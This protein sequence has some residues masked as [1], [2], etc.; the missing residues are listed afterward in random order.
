MLRNRKPLLPLLVVIFILFFDVSVS[1]QCGTGKISKVIQGFGSIITADNAYGGS[2]GI[3][4]LGAPDGNG[5]Y[6]SN[7][8]QYIIIDLLDTVAVGQTYSFIWRQYQNVTGLSLLWWSESTDGITFNPRGNISTFN[9]RYFSEEVV[10]ST[11]TRYIKIYMQTGT[12]DFSVD[13]VSYYATKCFSDECGAEYTSQLISGNATY[14]SGISINNSTYANFVPDGTGALINSTSDYARFRLPYLIPAGQEYYIIWR[15]AQNGSQLRIRESTDGVSWSGY[16]YTTALSASSVFVLHVEKA[17]ISTGYIEISIA[18]G[19]DIYLDALVFNAISCNPPAP[20]LDVEGSYT[21]CGSPISIAPALNLTDLNN[22]V[23]NEAYVQIETSYV[24]GQDRLEC[25][26]NYGITATWNSTYG[27]LYLSGQATVAQYQSVLRTVTYRNLSGTPPLGT[28]QIVFSLERFNINTN[29]YYRFVSNSNI[30][31]PVARLDAERAFLYGMQGYLVTITSDAENDF[32]LYQM[33]S[34]GWIG[35]SDFY[36]AADD[37]YWMTGPE[38]GTMFWQG[39]ESGTVITYANWNPGAEPNNYNGN[40]EAFAHIYPSSSSLSGTWNDERITYNGYS[41]YVEFGGMPDDPLLD[42]YGI[43]TVEIDNQPPTLTGVFPTG[44]ADMD[45]CYSSI[46]V[47]PSIATI[48]ALYSD[49]CGGTITV[50]KSGTPTGNDCSWSVTYTYTVRDWRGNYVSSVPSI[51][52]SGGDQTAPVLTG[53]FPTGQT[54]MD[55]CYGDIPAGP[56]EAD[57]AAL[58]T[59]AC[60]GAI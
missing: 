48:A 37:W 51:T 25:T 8:G 39:E 29:H 17:G 27:V 55:L 23:V 2:T 47:G 44:Q 50:T 46:P 54:G 5:A 15:P 6:F 28:K 41:Y 52:Y 16:K 18:N 1:A 11:P 40:D 45:L 14:Y 20:D 36:Y 34:N 56:T 7:N 19:S 9:E 35:G 4:A 42:L 3:N 57:I 12:A 24:A 32:L 30:R 26:E 21:Y 33:N 38:A 31:W 43:V 49:N 53:V 58:Y 22:Q 10:A 13:A 60:G 59:D